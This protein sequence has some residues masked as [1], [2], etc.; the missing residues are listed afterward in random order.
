MQPEPL[1]YA[2]LISRFSVSEPETIAK[3]KSFG[4]LQWID[5]ACT[6]L[7]IH[8][9]N[10][11]CLWWWSVW[12][13]SATFP[14]IELHC[15]RHHRWCLVHHTMLSCLYPLESYSTLSAPWIFRWRSFFR[16]LTHDP[17]ALAMPICSRPFWLR[18]NGKIIEEFWLNSIGQIGNRMPF[19]QS[20][21]TDVSLTIFFQCVLGDAQQFVNVSR[22]VIFFAQFQC[23]RHFRTI[24]CGNF[25]SIWRLR[26]V[27]SGSIQ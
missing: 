13:N 27:L 6:N 15:H 16:T 10:Y 5:A 19:G 3:H 21:E 9:W 11:R 7:C 23:R 18:K 25:V 2:F 1:R 8:F 26:N 14:S 22:S 12:K 4:Q 24:F 17:D 20:H